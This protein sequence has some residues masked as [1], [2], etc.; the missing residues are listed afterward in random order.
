MANENDWAR[1]EGE[2][3]GAGLDSVRK[4][5]SRALFVRAHM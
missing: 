4:A 5:K 1:A 2:G 3:E